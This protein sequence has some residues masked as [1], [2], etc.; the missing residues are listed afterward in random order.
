MLFWISRE[1]LPICCAIRIEIV[2]CVRLLLLNN[3]SCSSLVTFIFVGVEYFHSANFGRFRYLRCNRPCIPNDRHIDP[4]SWVI[5]C[6]SSV[7]INFYIKLNQWTSVR[8][9]ICQNWFKNKLLS[10]TIIKIA[11]IIT[12]S[13]ISINHTCICK[14]STH[15]S[16][17]C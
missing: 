7:C 8:N 2:P 3:L 14:L 15:E 10:L 13:F 1:H 6:V 17:I 12:K 9:K 11:F 4:V 16:V 5:K